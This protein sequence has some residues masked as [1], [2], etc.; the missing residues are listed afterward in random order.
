MQPLNRITSHRNGGYEAR[1]PGTRQED[2][3]CK[4]CEQRPYIVKGDT[5]TPGKPGF[6]GPKG[7]SG[8]PGPPGNPGSQGRRVS[9]L[10]YSNTANR[11][12][13]AKIQ[14]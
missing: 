13:K 6:D 14:T 12:D 10:P 4:N 11:N 3:A 1:I 8:E 9:A 2:P 5:G 7:A